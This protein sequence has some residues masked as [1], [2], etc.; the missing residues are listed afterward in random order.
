[1]IW[2]KFLFN[3]KTVNIHLWDLSGQK[4]L[5]Q[6]I[7]TYFKQSNAIILVYDVTNESS[8]IAINDW[9]KEIKKKENTN[10][11]IVLVGQEI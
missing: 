3:D 11:I 2:K 6:N 1:M 9:M 7:E 8:F 10:P 5:E 4:N